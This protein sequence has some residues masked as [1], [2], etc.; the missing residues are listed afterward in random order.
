MNKWKVLYSNSCKIVPNYYYYYDNFSK[1]KNFQTKPESFLHSHQSVPACNYGN[2][3]FVVM[4]TFLQIYI[5]NTC[6]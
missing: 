3:L 2:Y 6:I 4:V 5:K 1:L